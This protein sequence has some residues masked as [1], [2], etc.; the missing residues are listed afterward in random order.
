LLAKPTLGQGPEAWRD[1]RRTRLQASLERTFVITVKPV[2]DRAGRRRF[3]NFP[4]ELYRRDPH[5]I[6]QPRVMEQA[7]FRPR[8]PFFEHADLQMFLAFDGGRLVGRIA[9]IDDHLHNRTHQD[10]LA[11]FG[12]F[13]AASESAARALFDA[14]EAWARQRQRSR[15]RG[16]LNSSLNETAGLLIDAFD[17]DPMVMMPFNPPEYAGY[18]ERAGYCKVKDLYAW[19]IDLPGE[20]L[21]ERWARVGARVRSRHG[22]TIR[23]VDMAAFDAE[24]ERFVAVYCRAWR[25]NWG[26]VDPTPAEVRQLATELRH[27]VDTDLVIAAEVDGQMVG[28]G[29]ALPDLNQVFKGTAGHLFPVGLW[30]LLA[31]KRIITQVRLL[32]FG[33]VPEWRGNG[34][35]APVVVELL[36]RAT[37]RYKRAELSWVL[38]DN[39]LTNGSVASLGGRRYKTYRLYEKELK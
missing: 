7:R 30:R 3:V 9:A 29:I 24:I 19:I 37:R 15:I 20:A 22:L 36:S 1:A 16:P 5:W 28:C 27:V 4:Y 17:D 33:I 23:S 35:A 11:A 26:F 6:P 38:E 34:L 18:I 10:N 12:H 2:R 25:G 13:E 8:H 39:E 31:R 21:T 32:L 14:A